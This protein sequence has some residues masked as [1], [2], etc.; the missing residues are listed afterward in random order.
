[1]LVLGL[2]GGV[3]MGKSTV[4]QMFA[5]EGVAVFDA[6]KTV[7]ALYAGIAVE[8]IDAAFPGTAVNGT[9][10]RRRL[11][12]IVTGDTSALRRLEAIV[13]PLVAEAEAAFLAAAR[14]AGAR[15]ALLDIPLL[16][17]TGADERVDAVIVVSAPAAVQRA[18]ILRRDHMTEAQAAVLTSRQLP[19]AERRRRAHFIVETDGEFDATRQQ[20]R[21]I[22]R[23]LAARAVL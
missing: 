13:H 8:P 20:V 22:L 16:F 23:A 18:R 7:H 12:A 5:D 11:A 10:D 15:V 4:A 6:D 14:R 17:E 19:D 1:M 9:V 3:A 2:T 21:D